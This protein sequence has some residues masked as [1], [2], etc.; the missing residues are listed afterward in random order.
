M[1]GADAKEGDFIEQLFICSNHD[2]LLCFTDRGKL[3][4]LKVYSL[5]QLSRQSK[6][7]AIVNLLR[8]ARNERITSVVP[9]RDFSQ[10]YLVMAT[11]KGII[12]KTSLSAF[13]RPNRGG[14]IALGL[15]ADDMLGMGWCL[16]I[17]LPSIS[18]LSVLQF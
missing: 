16:S 11:A 14:I 7:R 15:N 2:Y 9:V 13:S 4:W 8:L 3:Y 17:K 18:N 1:I 12:K 10:G 6:G 5:P